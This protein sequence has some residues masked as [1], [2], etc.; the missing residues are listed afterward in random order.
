MSL[1]SPNN[2]KKRYLSRCEHDIEFFFENECWIRPKDKSASGLVQ[3]IPN[4]G[5]M[6]VVNK[7]KEL[8]RAKKPVR[9]LVLKARQWG[10][11]TIVQALIM[12]RSRFSPFHDALVIGNRDQTTKNLMAMN[13]RMYENFSPAVLD[14]WDRK[15]SQTDRNYEWENGSI[16]QIDTAGQPEAARS[17]TRD[18]IHG[19]EV[20]F[21]PNGGSV[22]DA[23]M[24]GVPDTPSSV[25]ILE[26]T[27]NGDAGVFWELWE[28]SK[29][30][31]FSDWERVFVPWS[32][33]PEYKDAIDPDLYNLGQLAISGD[34]DALNEIRWLGEQERKWLLEGE[35]NIE[36][37]H[38]R[39]RIIS[40]KFKGREEQ[41]C[42]EYPLDEE[43]AFR[44][45]AG[46]FLTGY[47]LEYQMRYQNY[48]YTTCDVDFEVAGY[49]GMP[50][51]MVPYEDRPVP[52]QD[53]NGWIQV[54]EPPE[55]G[56]VYVMGVDPA[57]GTGNDFSAFAVRT[58]GR[59]V[60]VGYRNDLSTDVFAEYIFCVGRWYDDATINVERAG[61]GLAVINT[62]LR[63]YYPRLYSTEAF[64]ESGECTNKR[65]GFVPSS[66]NK[67]SLLAMFR[68]SCNTGDITLQFPRLCQEARWVRL[69]LRGNTE[70]TQHYDWACP[71]K[72]RKSVHGERISDDL[73]TA[74]A[75]TEMI[76]R[77]AEWMQT[78]EQEYASVVEPEKI[79]LHSGNKL[80]LHNPLFQEPNSHRSGINPFIGEDGKTV[81][82]DPYEVY[83]DQELDDQMLL[84][85]P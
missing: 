7:I 26:S 8:Q 5:Q 50:M 36:Q 54:L 76:A 1:A 2:A 19:T 70:F 15:I 40:T 16:L 69:V 48:N 23:M 31:D 75:L 27:S 59:V 22:L 84:P 33:H 4:P 13:R 81:D 25:V 20:A 41:F 71:G 17:S 72:G 14:G 53:E 42:R 62:L 80:E 85:L 58:E 6:M 65:I 32:V 56:N 82:Y 49:E 57:E 63:L 78:I 38:W 35:L 3:L 64:D 68:H 44:A 73:F 61:G 30:D 79:A 66:E 43:E 12:H 52:E 67:K 55:K 37:L 24:P 74:A 9:I 28:G 51:I 60:C 45:A 21:W 77:D 83:P 39:R 46:G 10:S 47:G 11:S 29:D 34:M 18:F